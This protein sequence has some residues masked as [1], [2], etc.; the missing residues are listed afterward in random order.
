MSMIDDGPA[1]ADVV[2]AAP[3]RL[4]RLDK[5]GFR[6]LLA[7]HDALSLRIH[8]EFVKVL[9]ARLRDTTARLSR[10]GA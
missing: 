6:Y 2:V 8:R 3:S 4:I 7:T 10:G 1:A 5:A 9:T